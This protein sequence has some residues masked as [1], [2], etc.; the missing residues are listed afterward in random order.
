M[1]ETTIALNEHNEHRDLIANPV[2]LEYESVFI[3]LAW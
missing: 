1:R 3:L 2:S